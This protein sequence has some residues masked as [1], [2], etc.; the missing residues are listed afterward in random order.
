MSAPAPLIRPEAGGSPGEPGPRFAVASGE[1]PAAN[2]QQN[3]EASPEP[4]IYAEELES[5][6]LRVVMIGMAFLFAVLALVLAL[7]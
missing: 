5:N 3:D 1:A 2:A 7:G 6:P 4:D